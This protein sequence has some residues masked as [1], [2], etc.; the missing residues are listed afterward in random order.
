MAI[1]VS[2]FT[3]TAYLRATSRASHS[4]VSCPVTVPNSPPS[5][6]ILAPIS[7]CSSVGN[8]PVPT[9]VMYALATPI[10]R[11]IVVGP[12]P[13]PDG[14]ATRGRVRRGDERIRAVV[15]VEQGALGTLEDDVLAVLLCL[16]QQQ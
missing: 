14:G 2:P 13:D 7:S 3:R 1:S 8:G 15:D 9:L 6:T 10:T 5:S 11:S 12:I 4:G 16:P